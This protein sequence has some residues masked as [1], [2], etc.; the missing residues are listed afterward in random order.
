MVLLRCD[1]EGTVVVT[2]SVGVEMAMCLLLLGFL[3]ERDVQV[4]VLDGNV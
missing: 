2:R 1:G 4:M 3:P